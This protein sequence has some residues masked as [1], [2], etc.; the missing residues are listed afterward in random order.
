MLKYLIAQFFEGWVE[1]PLSTTIW[2][3]FHKDKYSCLLCF[4][5]HNFYEYAMLVCLIIVK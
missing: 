5:F 4:Y 1:C 3:S 2:T